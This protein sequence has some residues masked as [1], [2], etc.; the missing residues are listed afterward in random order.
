MQSYTDYELIL[1]N[2]GS[3][4]GSLEICKEY[5]NRNNVILINKKNGGLVSARKCGADVAKG[6]YVLNL[7]G[8]DFWIE[9]SFLEKITGLI[10]SIPDIDLICTD[11]YKYCENGK[12]CN[13]KNDIELGIYED[14]KLDELRSKYLYDYTKKGIFSKT[15]IPS[16]WSKVVRRE[17]YCKCQSMIDE[18]ITKGED[19]F[20][21]FLILSRVKKLVVA[22]ISCYAYRQY[23]YSM[24]HVFKFEDTKNLK[25]LISCMMS[26]ELLSKE[27][28]NQISVYCLERYFAI[29]MQLAHQC[30]RYSIFRDEC[31]KVEDKYLLH[32][33]K[34]ASIK[35]HDSKS[36]AK[37]CTIKHWN[38][39]MLFLLSKI[40]R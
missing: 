15:I 23:D 18:R 19:V 8:D 34:G 5:E 38:K 33:C 40:H 20:L 21:T 37:Y 13:V 7:D 31:K 24:M 12:L 2:D 6:E 4:D 32:I 36:R 28:T 16:I 1:V 39:A 14:N 9:E 35:C 29:I 30:N 10:D 27:F 22:D 11:F 17:I 3:S 25:T 26:N